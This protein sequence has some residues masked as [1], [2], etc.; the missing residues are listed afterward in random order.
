MYVP[1]N[2]ICPCYRWE[3]LTTL[4]SAKKQQLHTAFGIQNFSQEIKETM[5]MKLSAVIVLEQI[6]TW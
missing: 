6:F 1:W 5:V 4:V 2:I 3:E